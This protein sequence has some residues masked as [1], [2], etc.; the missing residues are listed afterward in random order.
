M[1]LTVLVDNNTLIDRYFKGEPALSYLLETDNL[2]ILFDTGYSNIFLE[3]ADKMGKDLSEIDRLVLSHGHLDH[4]WGLEALCRRFVEMDFEGRAREK[5]LLTAH[6]ELLTPKEFKGTPIGIHLSRDFLRSI[7]EFQ[8]SR[9][10]E[11]LDHK[12]YFLG[13]IPQ[14]FDF[15]KRPPIGSLKRESGLEEDHI[16]DDTALVY[17]AEEGIVVITG[18]SHSGICSIVEQAKKVSGRNEVLAVIGGFHLLDAEKER[19]DKTADYLLENSV[20]TV[21]PAHCTDL[22]SKI[23]LAKKLNIKEVG[24]GLELEFE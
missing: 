21:Y 16:K 3:N 12:L 6:P 9:G 5:V 8:L 13:E 22:K 18:C 15:E 10:P 4:T 11:Q 1:K 14:Y 24:V 19:L 2:K 17:E 20:D 7:F 23:A